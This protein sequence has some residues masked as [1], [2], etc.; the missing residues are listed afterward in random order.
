V[1]VFSIDDQGSA[2][3]SASPF[4]NSSTEM[5]SGERTKAMRPPRGG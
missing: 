1:P 5:P 3:S 4:Y 2:G